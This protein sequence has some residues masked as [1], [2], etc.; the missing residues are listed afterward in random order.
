M[1]LLQPDS[2]SN[3][4]GAGGGYCKDGITPRNPKKFT[5][6]EAKQR[7]KA[8]LK[9]RDA[10]ATGTTTSI[11]NIP[12]EVRTAFGQRGSDS[13][14]QHFKLSNE[15]LYLDFRRDSSKCISTLLCFVLS[16]VPI[17]FQL[18]SVQ[19]IRATRFGRSTHAKLLDTAHTE[20]SDSIFTSYPYLGN[21]T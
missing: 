11:G 9:E 15:S 8:R 2:I 19:P 1:I 7:A 12:I 6:A 5:D 18:I 14:S 17:Y 13:V 20:K 10:K 4:P 16:H 21:A 3:R